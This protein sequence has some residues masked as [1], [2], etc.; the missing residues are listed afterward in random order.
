MPGPLIQQGATVL[1]AHGGQAMP[2]VPN[3][4]VTLTG[5]PS[6]LLPNPWV[7][8]GCPGVPL[9]VP[10][11]VTGQWIVGTV[12]VTSNGQPLV[13]QTGVAVCTPAGTPLLPLVTQTRV[14][15]T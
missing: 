8:A 1:C 2:T 4:A 15:A 9:P 5:M 10:P 3:P 11:C 12:R 6:A 13:I 7:I 14:L